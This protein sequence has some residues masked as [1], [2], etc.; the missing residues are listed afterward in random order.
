[1]RLSIWSMGI[2]F[3]NAQTGNVIFLG[4]SMIAGG[5]AAGAAASCADLSRFVAGAVAARSLRAAPDPPRG[6]A[7]AGA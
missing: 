4:I 5:L 7:R 1:M 3:A 6:F 2:V